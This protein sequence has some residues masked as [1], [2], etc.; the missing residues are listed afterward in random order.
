MCI[1]GNCWG[2]DGWLLE[3]VC[4]GE[5][6]CVISDCDRWLLLGDCYVVV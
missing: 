4:F 1:L 3:G 6:V 2:W 5:V